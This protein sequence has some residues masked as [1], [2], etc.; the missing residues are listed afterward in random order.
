MAKQANECASLSPGQLDALHRI[1]AKEEAQAKQRAASAHVGSVGQRIEAKVTVERVRE[2]QRKAYGSSFDEI[3]Y[4]VTMRD[5]AG[6]CFVSMSPSFVA[7]EGKSLAIRATV[8]EHDAFRGERQTKLQ[9][10]KLV[11]SSQ[12]AAQA[13]S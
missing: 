4:I 3:V 12:P 11:A 6:N 5:E 10:I 8:K 7:D 9:R 13:V 2:F 1:K